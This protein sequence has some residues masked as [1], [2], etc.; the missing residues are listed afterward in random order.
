MSTVHDGVFIQESNFVPEQD[1]LQ[2]GDAYYKLI[3]VF[4]LLVLSFLQRSVYSHYSVLI[5]S[6]EE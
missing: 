1:K 2:D 5:S 3:I 6:R 4:H